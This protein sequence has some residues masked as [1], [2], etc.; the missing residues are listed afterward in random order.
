MRP[1]NSDVMEDYGRD[2]MAEHVQTYES[3]P[4]QEPVSRLRR[5]KPR[6]KQTAV[7][8][9]RMTSSVLKHYSTPFREQF[10]QFLHFNS[11][12]YTASFQIRGRKLREVGTEIPSLKMSPRVSDVGEFNVQDKTARLSTQ[13]RSTSPSINWNAR[14]KSINTDT[15][16]PYTKSRNDKAIRARVCSTAFSMNGGQ[17][18]ATSRDV[19]TE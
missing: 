13:A 8:R 11:L 19:E 12:K 10:S 1:V 18:R 15:L 4:E 7:Q 2:L 16:R 6:D 17:R 14:R 3:G 5:D 9:A